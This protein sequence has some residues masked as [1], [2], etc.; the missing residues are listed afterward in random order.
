MMLE[1]IVAKSREQI[2]EE[3]KVFVVAV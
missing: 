2:F 1:K 3:I